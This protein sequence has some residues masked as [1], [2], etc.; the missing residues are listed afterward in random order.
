[1]TTTPSKVQA[2]DL[3]AFIYWGTVE[4]KENRGKRLKIRNVENGSEFW[5]NGTEL[6]ERA[7]SADR[8]KTTQK[9]TMT[10]AAEILVSSRNT[11]FTVVFVKSDGEERTLRGRLV[12]P[13]PLLGRSMVEDLD[14]NHKQH[15]LSQ[16][17]H[18]TIKS[19]VVDGVKYIVGK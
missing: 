13:E 16:V 14:I 10:K 9:V 11:P 2:G 4:G 18:R 12:K 15:R 8:F 3:M 1:M 6:I 17:Y 7:D 19:L 5:V